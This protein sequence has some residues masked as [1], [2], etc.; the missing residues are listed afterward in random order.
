MIFYVSF[1]AKMNTIGLRLSK[2]SCIQNFVALQRTY[3]FTNI[4]LNIVRL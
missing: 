4:I 1:A 3:L 2:M